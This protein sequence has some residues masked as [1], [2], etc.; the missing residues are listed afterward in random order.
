MIKMN[1]QNITPPR[2]YTVAERVTAFLLLIA[3]Y[4]FKMFVIDTDYALGA[5]IGMY[6]LFACGA[7]LMYAR[8]CKLHGVSLVCFIAA[9]VFPI[10]LLITSSSLVV[11]LVRL[12]SAVMYAAA[13]YYA[14]ENKLGDRFG[15]L[16][17]FEAVKAVFVVPYKA[18]SAWFAAV[19][20]TKDGKK[21]R[22]NVL[23]AIG[24]LFLAVIPTVIVAALL[25]YDKSFSSILNGI[26]FTDVFRIIWNV[27]FSA[28]FAVIVFGDVIAS[29]EHLADGTMTAESCM[30]FADGTKR[31]PTALSVSFTLPLLVVYGIFFFSQIDCYVSAF[32][33][34]LPEGFIYAE[35][36]R[37]GFFQLCTVSAINGAVIATTEIF[38]AR[39][40]GKRPVI[41]KIVT[42]V[43]SAATLALIATAMSKMVMY[44]SMYGLTKLRVYASWFM[45]LLAACFVIVIIAQ[46]TKL[47]VFLS[48]SVA[49]TAMLAV[50]SFCGV[51]ARIA[52]YNVNAFT[53][54]KLSKIDISAMY[55]L[56]EDAVP[57]V[58]SLLDEDIPDGVQTEINGYAS[59]YA[60]EIK[61]YGL[62]HYNFPRAAAKKALADVDPAK[63][64]EHHW[65][66]HQEVEANENG[67][68]IYV[69]LY[70]TKKLTSLSCDIMVNG[71]AK[72]SCSSE[73]AH[74]GDFLTTPIT[75]F[76]RAEDVGDITPE[77][78]VY[79]VFTCTV[80]GTVQRIYGRLDLFPNEYGRYTCAIDG[81]EDL[82]VEFMEYEGK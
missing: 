57:Y 51:D 3:G 59:I 55:D 5:V 72:T 19:V 71:I 73:P 36:A 17:F 33:G 35:Y 13:V 74:K 39:P 14:F 65:D 21:T 38:G 22:N 15:D 4:L 66:D 69:K 43:L 42:T 76:F 34:V 47:R 1:E 54:G 6:V 50:L 75:Y 26:S 7:T 20:V 23:S 67:Y 61:D 79:A 12:Y 25:S 77:D 60:R 8:G 53:S 18:M 31:I 44:I 2:E 28:A 29:S 78:E 11:V 63:A 37:Q 16:L 48:V 45:I 9:A 82:T 41:T 46:Y 70:T 58:M 30:K 68:E 56:S 52:E 80:D 62:F 10:A 27:I 40:D 32:T 81:K 64:E 24:G 49:V